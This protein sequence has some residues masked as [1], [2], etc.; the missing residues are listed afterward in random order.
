MNQVEVFKTNVSES[1]Q[2]QQLKEHLQTAFPAYD[3]HFDL[4]DAEKI[5]RIEGSSIPAEKIILA[6]QNSGFDCA[7]LDT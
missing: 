5:L 7:V 1:W 4:E 6:V 2:A 3:I